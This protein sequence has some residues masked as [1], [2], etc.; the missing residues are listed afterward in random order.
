MTRLRLAMTYAELAEPNLAEE[1]Q[2]HEDF[3]QFIMISKPSTKDPGWRC[4][5]VGGSLPLPRQRM[6]LPD[7]EQAPHWLSLGKP[8]IGAP[9][10][11]PPPP[12][13]GQL[14]VPE[15]PEQVAMNIL[16]F[17]DNAGHPRVSRGAADTKSARS[18]MPRRRIALITYASNDQPNVDVRQRLRNVGEPGPRLRLHIKRVQVVLVGNAEGLV[19]VLGRLDECDSL[20]WP[21]L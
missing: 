16:Q 18:D 8:W 5:R 20:K 6:Q 14:P 7:P 3:C 19:V 17:F 21:R 9:F 11:R 2:T 12:H 15:H 10:R 4:Y 1:L 13:V